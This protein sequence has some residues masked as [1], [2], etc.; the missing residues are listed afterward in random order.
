MNL[1]STRIHDSE[2]A[3]LYLNLL[4]IDTSIETLE[5]IDDRIKI[6]ATK[7]QSAFKTSNR[8]E[9]KTNNSSEGIKTKN[10]RLAIE[11]TYKPF[12]IQMIPTK[13]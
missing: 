8:F 6:L 3:S 1:E 10:T 2:Y 11:V 9:L 5:K 13:I 12:I 4:D 7:N